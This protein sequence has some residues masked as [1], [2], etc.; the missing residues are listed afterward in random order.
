[1]KIKADPD[2][3]D[4]LNMLE[5]D[6]TLFIAADTDGDEK[7]DAAEFLSFSHPEE[8]PRMHDTVINQ[9]LKDKDKNGDGFIDFQV[10]STDLEKRFV[11]EC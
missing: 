8:D 7:L 3:L 9:V 2:R 1:M 4:E 11:T 10:W 5:E 6:R